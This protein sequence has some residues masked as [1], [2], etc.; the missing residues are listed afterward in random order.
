MDKFFKNFGSDIKRKV[1]KERFLDLKKKGSYLLGG[2]KG[3]REKSIRERVN[4]WGNT[5]S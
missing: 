3:L 4:G 1:K 2:T 5:G